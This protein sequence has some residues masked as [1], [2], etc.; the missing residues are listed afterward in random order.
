LQQQQQQQQY[1]AMMMMVNQGQPLAPIIYDS[2]G[3]M[4]PQQYP[5]SQ[6]V[7]MYPTTTMGAP[8]V[9]TV[10]SLQPIVNATNAASTTTPMPSFA[11]VVASSHRTPATTPASGY[12]DNRH[13]HVQ[14]YPPN[15]FSTAQTYSSYHPYQNTNTSQPATAVVDNWH[16]SNNTQNSNSNVVN[17]RNDDGM[18]RP[19]IANNPTTGQPNRG[20]TTHHDGV[21]DTV[22]LPQLKA[23][24][25]EFI[26]HQQP[27]S[28]P[29]P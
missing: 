20:S 11:D 2:N 9:T 27:T 23:A 28:P 19:D 6:P 18:K 1:M 25:Q 3:S 5:P 14:P 13:V 17:T 12:P 29:L 10:P 15:Q 16:N 4:P 22:N 21:T 24:A 26:P 7:M 8:F